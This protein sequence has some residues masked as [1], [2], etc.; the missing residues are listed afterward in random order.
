MIAKI[1][2]QEALIAI[3]DVMDAFDG[4]MV[5]RGDLG[6]NLRPEKVPT[7]Q[8][9]IIRKALETGKPVITAT[10]MLES[11]TY[12]STPTRAEAS[13]VANAVFEGTDAVMLSGETAVGAYPIEAVRTMDRIVREAESHSLRP[14]AEPVFPQSNMV[15]FCSAAVRLAVDVDA[16]AIAA[17]TRTGENAKI[18]SALRPRMPIIALCEDESM[19]STLTMWE[20][21][22]PLHMD[23]TPAIEEASEIIRQEIARKGMLPPGSQVI[24]VGVSPGSTTGRTDFIRLITV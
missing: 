17:L 22:L 5:A 7:A 11:M 15:G 24:V 4:V 1:E 19:I 9:Q 18:L 13:D 16:A 3:N 10:Q 8:K 21:I 23:H 6:V 14:L 2:R 12:N 20:A